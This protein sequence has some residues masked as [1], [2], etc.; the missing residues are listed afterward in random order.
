MNAVSIVDRDV[1]VC[2]Q[3]SYKVESCGVYRNTMAI[4]TSRSYSAITAEHELPIDDLPSYV[5]RLIALLD[6]EAFIE[7]FVCT[8]TGAYICTFQGCRASL[9]LDELGSFESDDLF[10]STCCCRLCDGATLTNFSR[11]CERCYALL[12]AYTMNPFHISSRYDDSSLEFTVYSDDQCEI[13]ASFHPILNCKMTTLYADAVYVYW[14]IAGTLNN[15][16][17]P[18]EVVYMIAI[19]A[20]TGLDSEWLQQGKRYFSIDEIYD[21]VDYCDGDDVVCLFGGYRIPTINRSYASVRLLD[22]SS[23]SSYDDLI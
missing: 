20:M 18:S 15:S 9:W 14:L 3:P 1:V 6:E 7:I 12:L 2:D 4:S 21:N 19:E 5:N 10:Q 17:L 23:D 22:H 11:L 8:S 16:N 13:T